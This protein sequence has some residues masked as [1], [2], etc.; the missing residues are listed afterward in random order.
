MAAAVQY[1]SA[2]NLHLSALCFHISR[3]LLIAA[4]RA[5]K[6]KAYFVLWF[7][8]VAATQASNFSAGVL[9]CKVLLGRSFSWRAT[10]LSLAW[11]NP[12]ISVPLG[13]YC[14]RRR[15]VFSLLPRCHGD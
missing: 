13:K 7:Q 10:A 14:L 5:R 12:D 4:F 6:A 1:A 15:L 2:A 3:Y 8:W 11:L 9:Y